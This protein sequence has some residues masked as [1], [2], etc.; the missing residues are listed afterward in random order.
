[1]ISMVGELM[2]LMQSDELRAAGVPRSPQIALY[3]VG[4]LP[5]LRIELNDSDKF[6]AKITEIIENA[7]LEMTDGEVA[8]EAYQYVGDDGARFAVAT[9]DGF[10]VAAIV[11]SELSD[12]QLANVLG[13]NTPAESIA[14]AGTLEALARTVWVRTLPARVL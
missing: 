10:A 11:P 2:G 7:D 6:D 13:V 12:D 3:G 8:G 1:M 5:V 9:I 4:M 14:D